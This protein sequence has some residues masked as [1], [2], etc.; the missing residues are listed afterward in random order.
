[1]SAAAAGGSALRRL[2]G[3]FFGAGQLPVAPGTWGSLATLVVALA[4]LGVEGWFEGPLAVAS[5]D[6]GTALRLGAAL[7]L[8]IVAAIVMVVGVQVG[9]RAEQD[10]GRKDPGPFVLD[11]VAGQLI[12]LAPLVPGPLSWIEA[13]AAFLLFRVF[14]VLKPP[15]CRRLEGLPGGLGIMADDVMA[16]LYA[17]LCVVVL[18]AVAVLPG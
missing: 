11:E 5:A 3:S 6:A 7:E 14:D 2:L 1:V 15:P 8:V 13:A 16:G 10:W 18:Q 17:A 12:A 4:L 9:H